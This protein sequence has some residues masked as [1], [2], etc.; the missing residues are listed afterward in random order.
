M[1][2]GTSKSWGCVHRIQIVKGEGLDLGLYESS[3][4][5]IGLAARKC[6]GT[7]AGFWITFFVLGLPPDGRMRGRFVPSR[8]RLEVHLG[9]AVDKESCSALTS[10]LFL[11]PVLSLHFGLLVPF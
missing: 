11:F 1:R 5:A 3:Y 7:A 4:T 9:P 8:V 2:T 6:Q 10:S